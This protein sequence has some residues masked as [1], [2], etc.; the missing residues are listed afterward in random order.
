MGTAEMVN[1]RQDFC[2]LDDVLNSSIKTKAIYYTWSKAEGL[3]LPGSDNDYMLDINDEYNIKVIQ[4]GQNTNGSFSQS[5]L[6]LCTENVPPGFALLRLD[7]QFH[8]SFL[9][10]ASKGINGVPYLSS[11]MFKHERLQNED[12]TNETVAIQGPSLERWSQYADKSES[13]TDRVPSI[14]CPFWPSGATEWVQR[15]RHYDWPTPSGNFQ[16]HQLR[17]PSC[18]S[19]SSTVAPYRDGMADIVFSRRKNISLGI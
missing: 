11:F 9:L 5:I 4:T 6:H 3:D 1:T 18:A 15:P 13:G 2:R 7:T 8:N 19:W 17:L 16:Y 14:R 10:C 12:Q